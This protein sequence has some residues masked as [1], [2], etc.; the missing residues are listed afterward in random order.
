MNRITTVILL[1]LKDAWKQKLSLFI[2]TSC[3]MIG[4]ALLL[5]ISNLHH[6]LLNSIDSNKKTLLGADFLISSRI[7][8]NNDT[9]EFTSKL[10][11][12]LKADL[13]LSKEISLASMLLANKSGLSRLV[14]LNAVD[15]NYPLYGEILTSK[16]TSISDLKSGETVLDQ[17]IMIQFDISIGDLITLGKKSF[18]VRDSISQIPGSVD[19]RGSIAPR[20][21]ININDLPETGLL[22]LGSLARY[23]Y[24][25][26]LFDKTDLNFV[27]NHLIDDIIRLNLRFES[28]DERSESLK[29]TVSIVF[30]FL[31][32]ISLL[33]LTIGS[34]GIAAGAYTFYRKKKDLV[35][36]LFYLG[37]T[38]REIN[39]LLCL[40]VVLFGA[41]G[42]IIGLIVGIIFSY[43]LP[44]LFSSLIPF[45]GDFTV[46][47]KITGFSFIVT[48]LVITIAGS[49]PFLLARSRI[50][51]SSRVLTLFK[52]LFFSL[53]AIFIFLL[54]ST[55]FTGNLVLSL[56]YISGI[57]LTILIL[58]VVGFGIMSLGKRLSQNS[59]KIEILQG[60]R[61]LYRPNNRT[62]V[63]II[64]IGLSAFTFFVVELLSGSSISK[65]SK[66]ENDG[67]ANLLLFDIQEDQKDHVKTTL[68][69]H[70]LEIIDQS[71]IV[72]MRITMIKGNSVEKLRFSELA[73]YER[74]MPEWTLTRE[75]R[76]SFKSSLDEKET[77]LKGKFI[78]NWNGEGLVPVSLEKG[79]AEKLGVDINDTLSFNVQGR[80]LD[81]IV[82][83]IREVDW[84][85]IKPNF[86]VIFPEGTLEGAP[87]T[88]VITSHVYSPA[89]SAKVQKTL[90]SRFGNISAIDLNLILSTVKSINRE[91]RIVI[92]S[93]TSFVLGSSILLVLTLVWSSGAI[94]L[95]ENIILKI[96]GASRNMILKITLVEYLSIA[97]IGTISGLLLAITSSM[98]FSRFY[99][100]EP[101]YI[102]ILFILTGSLIFI[103]L[104]IFVSLIGSIR[105]LN[106]YGQEN[107]RRIET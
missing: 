14:Q 45:P 66:L 56:Y 19:M 49:S 48:M 80:L 18:I 70:N 24:Y 25:Y 95:E 88:Y 22:T 34:L 76:S 74:K 52:S 60:Y 6:G 28:F 75:Y 12:R 57:V 16:G 85:Q 36:T 50:D 21:I 53:L 7:A 103:I 90:V 33:S 31:D 26:R 106:G 13:L 62:H 8:P 1:A 32:I 27:K 23:N 81:V 84:Q 92:Y 30:R 71:P 68:R 58:F 47:W 93:I 37:F 17:S 42:S 10:S 67:G 86:F 78:G 69:E 79:I 102:P 51:N 46:S 11:T 44:E 91:L 4:T 73:H 54:S 94:R 97:T 98:I 96:L 87:T 38:S 43:I 9:E 99:L 63:L 104:I 59:S 89:D 29:K 41:I 2:L 101:P 55:L 72:N 77:V 3:C 100:G 5:I 83:S 40:Q 35:L 15:S 61:N 82:S 105:V 39:T 107:L 65:L 64:A 20:A